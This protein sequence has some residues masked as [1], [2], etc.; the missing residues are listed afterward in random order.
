[1]Q[2]IKV[3]IFDLDNTLMDFMRMK[4]EACKAAV[5]AMIDAG[6]YM[7]E[8]EAYELLMKT[9]F[10]LGLESDEAFTEFLKETG[11]FE[12]KIL[13]AAI[14]SYLE[15]KS[16]FVKS[17]PHVKSVLK[18][19]RSNGITLSI[20][21]DAP[22]TKA[23]QRLLKMGIEPFFRFVVGYEDTESKKQTGL[24]LR[25]ALSMLKKEFPD[26]LNSEILMVGDSVERDVIPARKLGLR[27]ALCKYGQTTPETGPAEY[28]L[29]DIKELASIVK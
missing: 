1:M 17:Y 10:R 8:N 4:E 15:T 21:T 9:Y 5:R 2:K 27:T 19:L 14:N 23:Y 22:K 6:L 3:I 16:N 13:A 24:P 7:S 25:L 12:H 29:S 26:L 20:V 11:K 28:T 18:K